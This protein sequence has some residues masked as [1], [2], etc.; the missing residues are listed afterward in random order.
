MST[1]P[2]QAAPVRRPGASTPQQV[3]P[4]KRHWGRRVALILFLLLVISGGIFGY[5]ILAAGNKISTTDATL[6]GQIKDLLFSS[7]EF[8]EGEQDGRINI[9]LIAIGGEG[10]SGQNLADTIMVASV[11]PQSNE[12][13]L[14]SI[15]RDLYVQVPG[16]NY[17]SKINSV[18]AYGEA[19]RKD[20]GP[21]VLREKVSEIT[22]LPI[23]YYAR[24][25]FNGFKSIVDAVGGVNITIENSFYD[26]WHKINFSA[27]T[28]KMD[29]E[30]A[31]AYVRA[32]YVEGPEGGDFKRNQRQQQILLALREKVFSVNTAFDF[33]AV[34]G[35]LNSLSNNI[36][37][38]MQIWEMK[39]FFELARLVNPDQFHSVVLT[40][41]HNGVL[42]GDT[43]ILGDTPA[44][45]L[46]TR[47]GDY[48]EIQ[49]IAANIFSSP[50]EPVSTS[51]A[52][53]TKDNN[54]ETQPTSSP[55]SSPASESAVTTDATIEI[56]NGTTTT[57][58]AKQTSD[59]LKAEGYTVSTI[60]N[61]ANQNQA[62]TTV[63][64]LSSTKADTG[65]KLAE[66]LQAPAK[67]DPPSDEAD[68]EADILIILGT[69]A[70]Q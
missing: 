17:Y 52:E 31:L 42:V 70:T 7:G 14:L 28:E 65:Q 48:S 19:E 23:H 1:R 6:I 66:L 47:T 43:E 58:L 22:G 39:R 64:V 53:V 63:Y 57:G 9:L 61:A 16:E 69:N 40:T 13:A 10:H 30:R 8:L 18:H 44:S 33:Q 55:T 68:S 34:N 25:D 46:R 37:T 50:T 45:I 35:I 59:S 54:P 21:E 41:G 49:S 2:L 36:R 29:G 38:D 56:R 11:R 60:G 12:V 27:G 20:H 15:P 67:T 51:T 62:Q 4:A 32:R 26:F 3:K 5:K 24:V